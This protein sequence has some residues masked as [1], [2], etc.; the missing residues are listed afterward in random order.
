MCVGVCAEIK[1]IIPTSHFNFMMSENK[2][3]KNTQRN[4]QTHMK[5]LEFKSLNTV[6]LNERTKN[7]FR[8]VEILYNRKINQ[9]E[10]KNTFV[11]MLRLTHNQNQSVVKPNMANY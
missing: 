9:S 7:E 11:A 10:H 8:D 6:P 3:H 4:C 2:I 1:K 5:K